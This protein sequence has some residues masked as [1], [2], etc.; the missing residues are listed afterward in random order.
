MR[1]LRVLIST[2]KCKKAGAGLT[3][4]NQLRRLWCRHQLSSGSVR[5]FTKRSHSIFNIRNRFLL[6]GKRMLNIA[7]AQNESWYSLRRRTHALAYSNTLSF[8]QVRSSVQRVRTTGAPVEEGQICRN[9]FRSP[10]SACTTT[11]VPCQ[12]GVSFR[13]SCLLSPP[14]VS[15]VHICNPVRS[16]GDLSYSGPP[17]EP[18]FL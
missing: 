2:R 16:R 8:A 6:P 17:R 4:L 14:D 5:Y 18:A 10:Q 9:F 13:F 15:A 12:R 7:V 1:K 3:Y 11:F